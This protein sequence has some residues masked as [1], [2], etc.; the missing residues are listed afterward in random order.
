MA[1][2]GDGQAA[3][4]HFLL[5]SGVRDNHESPGS[6]SATR[7]QLE[8]EVWLRGNDFAETVAV[9]AAVSPPDRW[10]DRDVRV[11]LEE[12][13]RAIDRAQHPDADP[14]RPVTLR[15]FDWIVSPFEGRG[16]LMSVEIQLGA[17][18]AGPFAIPQEGLEAMVARVIA[19]ARGE[20]GARPAVH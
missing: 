19:E 8:I 16:V 12:L 15:G 4:R 20:Q 5:H 3:S 13:L 10:T 17:A 18:A 1:R 11:L 9:D 14:K 6:G 2:S 7:M